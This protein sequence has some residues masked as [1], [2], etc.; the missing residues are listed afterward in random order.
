MKTF[1]QSLRGDTKNWFKHLHPETISSWEELKDVF[2]KFWG[3]KK[4]LDLQ[5]ADFYALERHSNENIYVFS[6]RFSSIYY[7]LSQEIQL[8]E[9]AAMIHY[10][11]TLHLDLSFLL[12]ERR[13][14]SLKQMF[15]NAQDVQQHI[16]AC[17]QTQDEELED[18]YEQKMI[19]CDPEHEIGSI[20][21]P[22]EFTDAHDFVENCTPLA[23][24][25]GVNSVYDP[26]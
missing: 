5:L 21:G 19:D 2:L 18:E 25:G 11:T 23:K 6:R 9:V 26:S 3:N 20:I 12:M 16:Q 14:K 22:L 17:E 24:R 7:N 10:T 8:S 15:D 4:S 1:S 13:P